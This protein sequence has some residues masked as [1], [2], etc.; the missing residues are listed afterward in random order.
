MSLRKSFFD[1]ETAIF[2]AA[3]SS[4]AGFIMHNG[5]EYLNVWQKLV[6]KE[7]RCIVIVFII[8]GLKNFPAINAEID[9]EDVVYKNYYNRQI[10]SELEKLGIS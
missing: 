2:K 9:G 4:T 7:I 3:E 8:V 5:K 6:G 1:R 10:I